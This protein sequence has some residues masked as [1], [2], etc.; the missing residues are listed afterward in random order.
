MNYRHTFYYRPS[1]PGVPSLGPPLSIRA[2]PEISFL[3]LEML[4]LP[5]KKLKLASL[6]SFLM[7]VNMSLNQPAPS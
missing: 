4:V 6:V 5:S 3:F 7:F 2:G 1:C